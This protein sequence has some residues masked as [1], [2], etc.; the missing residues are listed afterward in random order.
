MSLQCGY[1]TEPFAKKLRATRVDQGDNSFNTFAKI[2]ENSISCPLIRTPT[3]AYQG[4][5]N[6]SFLEN[7]E[8]I[9]NG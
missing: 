4:V 2:S 6:L 9:R 1:F 5:R 7:F 3:Y 8:H